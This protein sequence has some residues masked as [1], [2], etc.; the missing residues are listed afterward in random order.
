LTGFGAR[1]K[2]CPE[3]IRGRRALGGG[4]KSMGSVEP[5]ITAAAPPALRGEMPLQTKDES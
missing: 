4:L 1:P 2:L 5:V 3:I